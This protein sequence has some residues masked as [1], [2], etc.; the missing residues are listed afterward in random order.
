MSSTRIVTLTFAGLLLI[1][2][3]AHGGGE[4]IRE[5]IHTQ[6]ETVRLVRV[7]G[8]LEHPWSL[9][10]LP[11]GRLLVTERPGRL[12]LVEDGAAS[13]LSGLPD[14]HAHRQGGLL[15]VVL[16]PE[17]EENGWVYLTYSKGDAQAT[18]TALG[19]AR[20][21]GDRLADFEELFVM[22]R[23]SA[24]GL[25]Y[26]SRLAFAPDGTLLMTIGDRGE[27]VRAQDLTD[28]A[29]STLRLSD[30]GSVPQDNPFAGHLRAAPEI[31][32][33]GHRNSQG[34]FVHPLTGTIW[35]TEHG[36]RGGDELNRVVAGANYGWPTVSRGL[37]Y[38][39]QQQIGVGR[40]AEGMKDP[41]VDWTPEIGPSGFDVYLGEA[42]E[43]WYGDFFAGSM[44]GS[45]LRRLVLVGDEVVHQEELLRDEI[46]RIRD[47]RSGPDGYLYL[48]TDEKDGGVYRLEPVR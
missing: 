22:N 45:H 36:P 30:D 5:E 3:T 1:A 15:E 27:D 8:G 18:A 35:Q 14:L 7:I 38:R 16:H 9:A 42:F 48:L 28:H 19:R 10:F 13:E 2:S 31:Y 6:Y 46:G 23:F 25:H 44:A 24:P 41:L 26:G 11:D 17:Y 29:G 21:D 37:D 33:Y 12:Q 20:I 47:V 39:T 40:R 34:M 43:S 32:S 4:V